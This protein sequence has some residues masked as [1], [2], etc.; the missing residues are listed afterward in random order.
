MDAL[1]LLAINYDSDTDEEHYGTQ[2]WLCDDLLEKVGKQV[3]I[4]R[5][6]YYWEEMR[7]DA[8]SRW[9]GIN[10]P[11]VLLNEEIEALKDQ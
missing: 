6:P 8:L 2:W 10:R 3:I 4:I 5:T 9:V 11:Q 7:I 1:Q